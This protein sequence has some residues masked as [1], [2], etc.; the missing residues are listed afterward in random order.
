MQSYAVFFEALQDTQALWSG[1]V[2]ILILCRVKVKFNDSTVFHQRLTRQ[3]LTHFPKILEIFKI[4]NF[5]DE[6]CQNPQFLVKIIFGVTLI[7]YW[8]RIVLI[9]TKNNVFITLFNKNPVQNVPK[10]KN[11]NFWIKKLRENAV[12][13]WLAK[14]W[15]AKDWRIF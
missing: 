10:I 6:L 11:V 14:D 15:H 5:F 12:Q 3:R 8:Y 13:N 7:L 1:I 9:L 2:A 4:Q